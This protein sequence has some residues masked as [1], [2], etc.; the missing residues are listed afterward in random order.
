MSKK[1]QIYFVRKTIILCFLVVSLIT[2]AQKNDLP[3]L[4]VEAINK[5]QLFAL[6]QIKKGENI[7]QIA[8]K[9]GKKHQEI[10]AFNGFTNTTSIQENQLLR[11]PIAT[12]DIKFEVKGTSIC[13]LVYLVKPGETLYGIVKTKF[14]L[15]LKQVQS[16]NG[17]DIASLKPGMEILMGY[18]QPQSSVFYDDIV[19]VYN[20]ANA[21]TDILDQVN[22]ISVSEKVI[23][24]WD[25][26]NQATKG[27]FVLFNGVPAGEEVEIYFPMRRRTVKAEVIGKIPEGTYAPEV[28]IFVS[29][30]VARKLGLFDTRFMAEI[31]YMKPESTL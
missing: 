25:K 29:P 1:I 18:F 16:I 3:I 22:L 12:N 13:K 26:Q 28:K 8:Q 31:R 20:N 11:I 17:K 30:L 27:M 15:D 9:Y 7:F 4:Q 23:G 14:G 19:D 21:S 5:D 6:H 24:Q 2:Y 10:T